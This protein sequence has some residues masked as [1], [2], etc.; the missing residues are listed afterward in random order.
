LP[1]GVPI[2]GSSQGS[3]VDNSGSGLVCGD[4][5]LK[6]IGFA[7]WMCEMCGHPVVLSYPSILSRM[8]SFAAGVFGLCSQVMCGT[9]VAHCGIS[10][11]V[12]GRWAS[13][14]KHS[15]TMNARQRMYQVVHSQN[16]DL[17]RNFITDLRRSPKSAH[18]PCRISMPRPQ[19][20]SFMESSIKVTRPLPRAYTMTEGPV[21]VMVT[22]AACHSRVSACEGN[23]HVQAVKCRPP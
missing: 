18:R 11:V 6:N 9:Y 3:F 7:R 15:T 12:S 16:I 5:L 22:L 17:V 23:R 13:M 10:R 4:S 14:M 1:R 20:Q 2:F 19:Y 21:A 8:N